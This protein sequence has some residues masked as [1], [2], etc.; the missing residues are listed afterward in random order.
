MHLLTIPGI[1]AT[2]TLCLAA[3]TVPT[4]LKKLV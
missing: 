3:I 1:I 4:Y 2:T